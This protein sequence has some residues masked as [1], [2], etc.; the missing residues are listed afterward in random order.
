VQPKLLVLSGPLGKSEFRFSAPV[1]IGRDAANPICIDDPAVAQIHCRIARQN[2][3]FLLTDQ[4]S[5]SGTFV[6]GIPVKQRVLAPGDQI[7][8]G[9][10]LF[11]FQMEGAAA[12]AI[13]PVQL[14]DTSAVSGQEQQL[15]HDELLYLHPESLAA[16]PPSARLDRTLSTLLKISTAIGSIRDVELTSYPPNVA[17][18]SW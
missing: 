7:A 1:S 17:P 13:S 15:R 2:D 9:S 3:S 10:S 14:D 6:N 5:S 11:L 18:S 16:L 12:A 8:V 4:D